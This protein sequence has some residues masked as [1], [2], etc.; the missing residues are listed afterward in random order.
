MIPRIEHSRSQLQSHLNEYDNGAMS[1]FV[2][3]DTYPELFEFQFPEIVAKAPNGWR[4]K[5]MA[6]LWF[7]ENALDEGEIE[8]INEWREKF[9]QYVLLGLNQHIEGFFSDEVNFCMALAFNF[10]PAAGK[11]TIYGE[12]EY[13][14]KYQGSRQHLQVLAHALVEAIPDLPIP[15]E[16]RDSYCMSCVPGPPDEASVQYRLASTVAK[17]LGV[18]FIDA[19]LNCPKPGLKGVTVEQKIPIWQTLYDDDCVALSGSIEDRLVVVVDDLYQSGATLWMYAKFLKEQG[20]THVFGLPCV[21]SLRDTDN[22]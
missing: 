1:L 11:R 3:S 18:D 14:L 21:K 13:Q 8:S 16:H 22:Q 5:N 10:D 9:A 15:P 7:P 4:Q 6:Y 20:A 19:D 12:A 17:K 2:P